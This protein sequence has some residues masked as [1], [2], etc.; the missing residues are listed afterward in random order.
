MNSGTWIHKNSIPK[1]IHYRNLSCDFLKSELWFFEFINANS[2]S[3]SQYWFQYHKFKIL[4]F[5]LFSAMDSNLWIGVCEFKVCT[6]EFIYKFIYL[7]IHTLIQ[8]IYTWIH[9]HEFIHS[10]IH[11]IISLLIFIYEFITYEFK[12]SFHKWMNYRIYT[13]KFIYEFM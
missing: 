11:M 10:W 12:Q 5:S 3:T 13:Y 4:N 8:N 2:Y 6:Y 7:W 1:C 9:I